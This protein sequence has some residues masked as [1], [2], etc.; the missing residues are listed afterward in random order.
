MNLDTLVRESMREWA[1]EAM[2][3]AGLAGKALRR[4]T[5]TRLL[6]VSSAAAMVATALLCVAV[7]MRSFARSPSDGLPLSRPGLAGNDLRTDVHSSPPKS[8]VA[9]GRIAISAYWTERVERTAANM[10]IRHRIWHLFDPATGTYRKAPWAFLDV[11]PGLRMAAVLEGPLPSRRVGLVDM[12]KGRVI[13]WLPLEQPAAGLTWSPDGSRILVTNY[14]H[15]PDAE[16]GAGASG[17]PD[18]L[19][20]SRTGF[21]VIQVRSGKARYRSLQSTPNY[22]GRQDFSWSRDGKLIGTSAMSKPGKI[23]YDLDGVQRPGSG[24][25]ADD[26]TDTGPSP[27]GRHLVRSESTTP[28]PR[29][30]IVVAGSNTVVSRQPRSPVEWADNDH[31]IAYECVDGKCEAERMVLASID[32]KRVVPLTG[33]MTSGKSDSW[34]PVLTVR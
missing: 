18:I 13:R 8:L 5:R 34:H 2:V 17:F 1:E 14:R 15:H 31:L 6:A 21:T 7:G 26:E 32:G 33:R 10:E 24:H 20:N 25:E 3:P 29:V 11:A 4:R 30:A 23:F 16:R 9:A 12:A 27:D 19:L 28:E 22:P